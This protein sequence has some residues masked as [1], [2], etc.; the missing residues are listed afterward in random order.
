MIYTLSIAPSIDYTLDLQD[1][2]LRVGGVNRPLSKGFSIGGKG[3]TVSR[4]LSNLKIKSTPIVAV[5]GENGKTIQKMIDKEFDH[6]I[7]LDTETDS[8][9]DVM[10]TGPSQDIRFDPAA[11]KIKDSEL[12][13][14]FDFF[15][16]DLKDGDILVL[17]G[18]L[19]QEDKKLYGQIIK[20]CVSNKNIKVIVDSVDDAL[21]NALSY[22]PFMIKPN[23]EELGDLSGKALT[24]KEDIINA[25]LELK[26]HG[27]KS[28]LVTLGKDGAYYFA[29][30]NSIYACNCATGTQISAVGAG[31][32]S[33]AG[34]IKG[35]EENKSIEECLIY[36]MAS[37]GA[38]AFS[39]YLGSYSLFEELQKQIKVTKI[40]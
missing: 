38:T 18:S 16:N 21:K 34:F 10:I 1:K 24:T 33:I 5:G 12:K 8:R 7:Y 9:I 4:M 25:A 3:I 23:Q 19:G 39:E 31:D 36:S 35:L 32:S 26:K 6:A 15:K 17:A 28:I 22:H 11:P 29:E 20:E 14:M 37:G 40:A 13:K 2:E 30:N 27:P